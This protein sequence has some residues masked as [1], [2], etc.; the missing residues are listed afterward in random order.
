MDMQKVQIFCHG[1]NIIV[2]EDQVKKHIRKEAL[3]AEALRLQTL[4]K[5]QISFSDKCLYNTELNS[6]MG[7]II[8]INRTIRQNVQFATA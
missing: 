7:K 1:K 4:L 3:V 2:D 6:V 8:R 5:G